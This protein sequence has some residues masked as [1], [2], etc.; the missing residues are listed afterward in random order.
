MFSDVECQTTFSDCCSNN[1]VYS[2]IKTEDLHGIMLNHAPHYSEMSA[3]NAEALAE[4]DINVDFPSLTAA[5]LFHEKKHDSCSASLARKIKHARS[6]TSDSVSSQHSLPEDPL[7]SVVACYASR[8]PESIPA[9]DAFVE[10]RH[11]EAP[12]QTGAGVWKE[13]RRKS[14]SSDSDV[15]IP[16]RLKVYTDREIERPIIGTSSSNS[17]KMLTSMAMVLADFLKPNQV[18]DSVEEQASEFVPMFHCTL[19][20]DPTHSCRD[21]TRRLGETFCD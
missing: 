10:L 20:G 21:C 8:T 9:C 3:F 12:S 7:Q 19:C 2:D 11:P 17:G 14:S 15:A 4:D 13:L 18:S 16:Q 6:R 1:D 5:A